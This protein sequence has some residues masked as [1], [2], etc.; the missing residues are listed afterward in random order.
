MARPLAT[1]SRLGLRPRATRR[2][3]RGRIYD[4]RTNESPFAL[5][6]PLVDVRPTPQSRNGLFAFSSGRFPRTM[7]TF[8]ESGHPITTYDGGGAVATNERKRTERRLWCRERSDRRKPHRLSVSYCA[9][10]KRLA[11]HPIPDSAT[12]PQIYRRQHR[13]GREEDHASPLY[14]HVHLR[15]PRGSFAGEGRPPC[16]PYQRGSQLPLL[17][18]KRFVIELRKRINIRR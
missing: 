9:S 13:Q 4:G 1:A 16:R 7:N 2:L 8:D 3:R 18:R 6:W 17:T 11:F 10:R 12:L 14:V 15:P 5:H